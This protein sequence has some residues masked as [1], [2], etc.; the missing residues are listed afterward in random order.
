MR[1]YADSSFLTA[2]YVQSGNDPFPI[3]TAIGEVPLPFNPVHRLEVRNAIRRRAL[4]T[5]PDRRITIQDAARAIREME[6]DLAGQDLFHQPIHWTEVLR[7]AER[8]SARYASL[9]G[10]RAYDVFHLAAAIQTGHDTILTFDEAQGRTARL[11]HLT[12]HGV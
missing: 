6:A 10:V 12:V 3:W 9:T 5:R 8:I 2:L 4:E 1:A 7:K 11:M